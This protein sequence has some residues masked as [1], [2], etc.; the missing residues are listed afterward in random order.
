[1]RILLRRAMGKKK[2]KE[3][4]LQRSVFVEGADT[5]G[6]D[7]KLAGQIFDLIEKFAGYGFNKSHSA[8]Y[9][10]LS[11]QTA[12]LKT[13][14]SSEFMAAVLSSDM[15]NTDKVLV[16]VE[17]CQ[18]M[19]LDLLSPNVNTG[20][21]YFTVTDDGKIVYGL[22]AIKGVG[23]AAIEDLMRERQEHGQ[24]KDLFDFLSTG[25]Y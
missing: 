1:M 7:K 3:M 5:K 17:E 15:D 4:A 8:A 22:G 14:Y 20:H 25:G 12:W 21:Y 11:Y 6:V 16:F 2:A 10:L 18:R 19:K 23:E 9:A 24:F 13:H